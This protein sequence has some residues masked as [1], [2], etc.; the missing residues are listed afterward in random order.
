MREV[1]KIDLKILKA[2]QNEG[3]LPNAELAE[4]INVSPATC[5]RRTQKLIDDKIIDSVQANI[6]PEAVNLGTLVMVGVILD[7]STP[8][9]F[10]N[11][12][13]VVTKLNIVLSCYLV[14]GEYDYLLKIRVKDMT[15][16][17]R[18]HS[19]K[20]LSLPEVRQLRTYFVMKEVVENGPLPL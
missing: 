16:F 2:L 20:L 10:A 8:E 11:F 14:A 12:E 7:R 19:D 6:K 9:S 13:S 4:K 17:N 3:R 18:L 15:D 5:H 1:D